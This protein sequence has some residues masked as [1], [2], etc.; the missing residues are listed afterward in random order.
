MGQKTNAWA[1]VRWRW[2]HRLGWRG[3]KTNAW[4]LVR[5]RW[6][7]RLGWRGEKTNAWALVRWRWPHGE[8]AGWEGAGSRG[9]S[10]PGVT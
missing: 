10:A 7:H 6:P 3:K 9:S 8:R 5:W 1:L 2:L 4:A